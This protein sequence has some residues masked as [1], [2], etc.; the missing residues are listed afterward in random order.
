MTMRS[1][2]SSHPKARSLGGVADSDLKM[3][4]SDGALRQRDGTTSGDTPRGGP[5]H[6]S[7]ER[8][9]LDWR[10]LATQTVPPRDWAIR[11]WLGMGHAT[12]LAG[13]G[14]IGKTL[15]GQMIGSA[16]AL[17]R[18]YLDETPKPRRVL[19][20]AAEDDNDEPWRRQ[21]AIAGHFGV[22][23]QSFADLLTVESFADRDCT[24]L[25]LDAGGRLVPTRILDEL[26]EQRRDLRAEVVILDNVSR[27]FAGREN[28]RNHV[29]RYLAEVNGACEGAAVL[30]LAHPGRAVGSEFS[31]SSAWE[32]ACRARLY[33]SDR[34]PD[35]HLFDKVDEPPTSD[36][37]YL[38]KRKTNYSAKDLRT[39][40]FQNGVLVPD[41]VAATGGGVIDTLSR[42]RDE[43]TVI[44]ATRKLVEMGQ[45][46]TDGST[47]PNYLPG[48]IAKFKLAEG[49][50]KRELDAAM[51]RLMVDGKLQRVSVGMYA[52]RTPRYGLV[53]SDDCTN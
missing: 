5:D 39:F 6:R 32:N 21:E 40:T 34:E 12:L 2:T 18:P 20:W 41:E 17:G 4:R 14:G 28:D 38:A 52:N 7:L 42:R 49:R 30:H 13:L 31:G 10:L 50:S 3:E 26:R 9:S 46:P 47:S 27:T 16:L 37:R 23:L 33:L 22:P 36:R 24:L 11:G 48:L 45:Q 43:R 44:E 29:T 25:D 15:L 35:A 19:F 1:S 51:R 53:I 8:R